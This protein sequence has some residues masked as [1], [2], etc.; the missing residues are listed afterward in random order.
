M[1]NDPKIVDAEVIENDAEPTQAD[2]Q[3]NILSASHWL[4]GVYMILFTVIAFVASYV[5]VVLIVIQFVFTLI[6]A[7]NDQRLQRFGQSLSTYI[8]QILCFL[9][10]NSEEK[11]F[12]FSDWP[13]SGKSEDGVNN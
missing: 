1:S 5:F 10:F 12:P 11:P 8:Y 6:T 13:N 9:T 2:W 7:E 3:T 4:R